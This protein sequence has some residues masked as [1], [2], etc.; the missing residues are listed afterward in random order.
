MQENAYL[1][2]ILNIIKNVLRCA[3]VLDVVTCKI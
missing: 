1:C 2:Y 3:N